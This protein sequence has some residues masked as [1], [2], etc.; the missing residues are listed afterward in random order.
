MGIYLNG[1]T[2]IASGNML[3]RIAGGSLT[4]AVFSFSNRQAGG[5][6]YMLKDLDGNTSA[7]W[8]PVNDFSYLIVADDDL[9]PGTYTLWQGDTQLAATS[10]GQMGGGMGS[11]MTPPDGKMPGGMDIPEGM[12][13][14][15]DGNG[16]DH[17]GELKVN[18]DGTITMPDGTIV[19]PSEIDHEGFG[20]RGDFQVNED[21]TIT[22]PDGTV[23]DPSEMEPP[24]G[25]QPQTPPGGWQG[26]QMSGNN[27]P[28][29]TESNPPL[30]IEFII[31]QGENYFAFVTSVSQ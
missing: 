4:Y 6:S 23:I 20:G 3:D 31:N 28:G 1:G 30:N 25:Q 5:T 18:E 16:F 26:G 29:G 19:D 10:E 11:M 7:Q 9:I 13:P 12:T 14:P 2:V 15:E 21:G 27:R 24:S 17:R 22:L 8:T